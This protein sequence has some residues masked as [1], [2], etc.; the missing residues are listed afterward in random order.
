MS[1]IATLDG[2]TE[3][4]IAY[5]QGPGNDLLIIV[6]PGTDFDGTFRAWD[7]DE[8]E[9]ITMNGW[10]WTFGKVEA[11]ECPYCTGTGM[12]AKDERRPCRECGGTGRVI[13]T[14]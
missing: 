6:K 13:T 7:S 2:Y 10:L 14:V 4:Y 11:S 1:N 8:G 3:D 9:Y 5:P 12:D